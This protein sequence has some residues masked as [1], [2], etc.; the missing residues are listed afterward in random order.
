MPTEFETGFEAD[1]IIEDAHI[2]QLISPI[3]GLETGTS[4]YRS[5]NNSAAD[6]YEVS[7]DDPGSNGIE[8]LSDGLMIHFKAGAS[9]TGASVL[10]V[11]GVDGNLGP[12]A[13]TKRGG[14]PLKAGDISANQMVALLC[15]VLDPD[16]HNF[17]ARFEMIGVAAGEENS[18]WLNGAGAPGSGLGEDG[19]FYLDTTN[20]AYYGPKSSGSW[21]SA[22]SLVG[23]QGV[24]G[25]QGDTGAQGP[26]GLNPEGGTDGQFIQRVAGD[27][28]WASIQI[29]DVAGLEEALEEVTVDR[30][31]GHDLQMLRMGGAGAGYAGHIAYSP[32][33]DVVACILSVSS[34]IRVRYAE[35]RFGQWQL[36]AS[37]GYGAT[38]LANSALTH[39]AA[40][41]Q[42]PTYVGYLPPSSSGGGVSG[43]FVICN[44]SNNQLRLVDLDDLSTSDQTIGGSENNNFY[45]VYYDQVDDM[46]WAICGS[47]ARLLRIDPSDWS[48]DA[49]ISGTPS[50]MGALCRDAR[51]RLWIGSASTNLHWVDLSDDSCNNSGISRNTAGSMVFA[52]ELEAIFI[53][54]GV[55]GSAGVTL[56]GVGATPAI[57][58][59]N[60]GIFAGESSV[61]HDVLWDPDARLFWAGGT[62]GGVA[63]FYPLVVT[64]TNWLTSRYRKPQGEQNLGYGSADTFSYGQGM[65]WVP[66]HR[67]ILLSC[68]YC[69]G[70]VSVRV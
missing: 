49:V 58:A 21:G 16:P 68:Y 42:S 36:V 46:L 14:D 24:V 8:E 41:G 38:S 22:N 3:H 23:P 2:K 48:V 26:P 52:P 67:E 37:G 31:G 50:S 12:F 59:S 7:F 5:D 40:D 63:G 13:I 10:T 32:D 62:S 29:G 43:K 17:D 55:A 57:L 64:E 15:N 20:H 70:F 11:V 56:L 65:A 44:A 9:N 6:T 51:D 45:R 61:G 54:G 33:A 30:L 27:P 66:G 28:A 4:F 25:P 69:A 53:G 1:D 19:D 34:A 47:R 35:R 39:T 60:T 18:A